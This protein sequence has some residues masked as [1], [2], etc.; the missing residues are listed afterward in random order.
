MH[1]FVERGGVLHAEDV[2]LRTLAAQVGT[3]FYCYSSATLTRHYQVFAAAFSKLDTLIC[4]AMKANSNQA[5]LATMARLGAGMDVV[6]VGELKR[7]LAAGVP[8]VPGDSLADA[9]PGDAAPYADLVARLGGPAPADRA[10]EPASVFV[11]PAF[12]AWMDRLRA[13]PGLL[14]MIIAL[15]LLGEWASRRLRGNR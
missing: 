10:G 3:P 4:Y 5:V 8:A 11:R 12:A 1:H 13:A 7:A 6:S 15:A 14:F 9:F 2:D